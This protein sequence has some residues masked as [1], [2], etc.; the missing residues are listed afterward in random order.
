MNGS[1]RTYSAAPG[2]DPARRYQS[3]AR[4]RFDESPEEPAAASLGD[5]LWGLVTAAIASVCLCGLLTMLCILYVSV[6][7]FSEAMYRRLSA[8]MGWGSLLDA[9]ALLLPNTT[10]YL[11][12][13]S[14]IPSLVGTSML[15]SNHLCPGD[16][17][18][19]L[20]LGRCVGLRGAVKV[21]LRNEYLQI[22]MK[23]VV[24]NRNGTTTL[25]TT[26]SPANRGSAENGSHGDTS[27]KREGASPDL[28][29][30]A[31]LLHLFLEFPLI[32]GED[33]MS[34]REH[35]FPLLRSFAQS[36]ISGAP[37]HFVFFPE[38]WSLHN[39]ANRQTLLAK[40]N[41]FAQKD[42]RPQ[43]KHLLLPRTRGF[44]ASVECLRESNPV[45]YDVTMV[46][47]CPCVDVD[48]TMSPSHFLVQAHKGYDG[49]L[50]QS[51]RLSS[52]TLWDLLLRR[53]P[54]EIHIR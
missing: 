12:G 39:G 20:M 9:A 36:S 2:A 30:M 10:I 28:S 37:V 23:D 22:N 16:W 13:D 38:A 54:S 15:I 49:S 4:V 45:V 33:Y 21:F 25:A 32:N 27:S 53:F 47:F 41:E 50:P 6:R 24:D 19:L 3:Q 18:A 43:L 17:W 1:S 34:D 5:R 31:K 26:T 7:P 14:D 11:T 48:W 8:Q 35:L 40:S 44:N 29:L 51:M 46:R 52:T 42:G